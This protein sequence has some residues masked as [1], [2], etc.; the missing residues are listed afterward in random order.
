MKYAIAM[1]LMFVAT[2]V[3]AQDVKEWIERYESECFADS[4]Q[5][6]VHNTGSFNSPDGE[7]T[8]GG[9]TGSPCW[10]ETDYSPI[11]HWGRATTICRR[12][13]HWI[14]EWRHREPSYDG[15]RRFV[16]ILPPLVRSRA[17]YFRDSVRIR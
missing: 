13:A 12:P 6:D 2:G 9:P 4:F 5:A 16:G 17:H 3:K 10:I 14:K 15:L 7:I 8:F 11:L 1:V